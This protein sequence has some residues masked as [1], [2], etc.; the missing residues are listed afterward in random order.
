VP[1]AI[2]YQLLHRTVSAL[3]I[4]EQFNAVAAVMI[5]QSFSPTDR[6]FEDFEAFARL[7]GA[8]VS[9]GQLGRLGEFNG[10]PLY[11]GWCKGDQR[12]RG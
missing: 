7:F 8:A 4:A 1:D 11:V 9:A 6:W 5:V 3:L 2:R 12:F 10:T